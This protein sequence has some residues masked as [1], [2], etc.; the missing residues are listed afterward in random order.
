MGVCFWLFPLHTKTQDTS[1]LHAVISS[2][3]LQAHLAKADVAD[4][5]MCCL[6]RPAGEIQRQVCVTVGHVGRL[7]FSKKHF[8]SVDGAAYLQHHVLLIV[9][10]LKYRKL[11]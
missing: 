6:R 8:A 4:T 5:E 10:P 9:C 11:K 2:S 7:C 1:Y 3:D